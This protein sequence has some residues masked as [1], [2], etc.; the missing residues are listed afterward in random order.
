V[1]PRVGVHAALSDDAYQ[2]TSST[3]AAGRAA[4][5][6]LQDRHGPPKRK[7]GGTRSFR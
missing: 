2:T 4:V 5:V 1:R 7:L 3:V 6:A